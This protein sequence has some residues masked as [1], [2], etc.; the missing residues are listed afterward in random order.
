MVGLFSV[1]KFKR[2][3]VLLNSGGKVFHT[4]DGLNIEAVSGVDNPVQVCPFDFGE[5]GKMDVIVV[6]QATTE[7]GEAVFLRTSVVNNIIDDSL[8]ITILPV[9]ASSPD[10]DSG[11]INA[12]IGVTVQWRITNIDGDKTIALLN[13]KTQWNYGSLQLPFVT[14]G[15]G[16][17]NNYIED[18]AVGYPGKGQQQTWTPI[19]PNSQLMVRPEQDAEWDLETLLKDNSR[20]Y[21]VIYISIVCL[22]LLGV[23]VAYLNWR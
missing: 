12:A 5:N 11:S 2:A 15:L 1:G 16:R 13:Q 18:L 4:V 9:L 14:D 6:S 7:Q 22:L 21:D 3:T 17:T 10:F 19:I 20:L 23:V 8:F